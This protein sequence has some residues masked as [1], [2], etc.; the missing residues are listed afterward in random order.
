MSDN[1]PFTPASFQAFLNEGKLMGSY[2]PDSDRVY[3]PPRAICPQTHSSHMEWR[4]LSGKGRLAAFTVIS[5]GLSQM[6][7]EGYGRDNPYCTGIVELDAGVKISAQIL[8]V[9]ATNPSSIH[10]GDA[11]EIA[12]DA[13]DGAV[14]KRL[15]FRVVVG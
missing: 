9:D 11:V 14:N 3:L 5:I 10:V 13:P 12:F 2:C 4:E 1:R 7:A 8:G 6:E 15:T